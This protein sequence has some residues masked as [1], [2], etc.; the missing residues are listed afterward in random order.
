MHVTIQGDAWLL[1]VQFV[2]LQGIQRGRLLLF[3]TLCPGKTST[4][5][6]SVKC[7]G[8]FPIVCQPT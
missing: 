2:V 7:P 5:V 4:T 1:D 6:S 8:G 3:W